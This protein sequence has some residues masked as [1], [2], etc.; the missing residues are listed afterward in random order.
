M[1][2]LISNFL[3]RELGEI[4]SRSFDA[5]AKPMICIVSDVDVVFG[6]SF[7]KTLVQLFGLV[8]NMAYSTAGLVSEIVVFGCSCVVGPFRAQH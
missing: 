4:R 6:V 1:P 3:Y 5:A 8:F 7:V 2:G